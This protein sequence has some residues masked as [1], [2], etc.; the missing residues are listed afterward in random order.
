MPGLVGQGVALPGVKEQFGS[1]RTQRP[2]RARPL[3]PCAA[4][5]ALK[6]A[7]ALQ[8]DGGIKGAD[9]DANLLIGGGGAALGSGDVRAALEQLRRHA[10][11][12]LGKRQIERRR[13]NAEIGQ[14]QIGNSANGVLILGAGHAYVQQ[15]RAH[16]FQLRPG[17]GHIG[18]GA[19]SAGKE[20]LGQIELVLEVGNGS[21]EQ[22][23]LRIQAA[24]LEVVG[25]H[26]GVEAQVYASHLRGAGLCVLAGRLDGAA[27]AAPEVRLPA[28]LAGEQ[29]VVIAGGF[30]G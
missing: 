27:D 18:L 7:R 3:N 30:A 25:G 13:R 15:L 14:L 29:K 4:V 5:H 19:D 28:C 2:K 11:W 24:Q 26:F 1:L 22:F 9:G 17:L 12:N 8:R 16:C 20:I 23:G 6:P 10:E 21:G